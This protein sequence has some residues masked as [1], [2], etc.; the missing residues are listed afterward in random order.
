M[1]KDT[2]QV[3]TRRF[4]KEL[5]EDVN[6]FH[7][8]DNS[9]T[10]ARNAINNSKT[11]DLGKLGN[12]PSNINCINITYTGC[13]TSI[14][15]IIGTIHINADKWLIYTTNGPCH[16]IGIFTESLCTYET[17]VNDPC[18]NFSATNL[19]KGV[20]RPVV[21]CTY[22]AY[23]DDGLNP[24]RNLTFTIDPVSDNSYLNPN[25][26]IPWIQVPDP[27]NSATCNNTINS[28]NLDCNKLRLA[29][30]ID[31]PCVEVQN[32]FGSGTLLNGSYM[33]AIAYT[34]DGQKIS[35]W[36]I[37]NVQS[38]F[39]HNNSSCSLDVILTSLDTRFTEFQIV[40]ISVVNQQTV[41]KLAGVYSTHQQRLSF[42]TI[43]NTWPT[44]PIEQIPIMTPIIDKTDAT[45][46]V[47]S[48]LIRTGTTS[49]EDFN[50]QPLANQIITKW[51]SIE[52][53]SNYYI[54]G[55][56][57]TNYLRDEVYSFFIRWVYDTGDKSSA[58]HI[59]GRPKFN[60]P[61][62]DGI[63]N[64]LD[65]ITGDP[66]NEE[67]FVGNTSVFT[68]AP[69][70]ILSDGG[71]VIGEGIMGYWES[72]EQYPDDN[73]EVWNSETN[74]LNP[75]FNIPGVLPYNIQAATP[76]IGNGVSI[77]GQFD[78]CGRQIRHH[79]FPDLNTGPGSTCLY[80]DP[81]TGNIRILGVA[82][83]N[84]KAPIKNDGTPIV[85]IV[86]YEIFRGT[87]NGNK[88]ILAKGLINNMREYDLPD[89]SNKKGLYANYPYNDLGAD[90]FLS[91]TPTTGTKYPYGGGLI[92]QVGYN[93]QASINNN[94]ISFHSPDTTFVNPF[95]SAKEI[96]IHGE[97]NGNITGKFELSDKH[98]REKLIKDF[99]FVISA[100]AGLGIAAIAMN[101]Q[102]KV[103][104]V[105]PYMQ[106]FSE[107]NLPHKVDY[108]N[109]DQNA[110][111]YSSTLNA[112]GSIF[113]VAIAITG[114]LTGT[115]QNY[116]GDTS[117]DKDDLI[118]TS[119]TKAD[120]AYFNNTGSGTAIGT[121]LLKYFKTYTSTKGGLTT[122]WAKNIIGK[123]DDTL[124]YNGLN[125]AYNI[126][127]ATHNGLNTGSVNIEQADGAYQN[128]PMG[129]VGAIVA[130]IPLFFNYFT[131]GTDTALNFF[132]AV[133][134]YKDYALRYHSHCLYTN[135]NVPTTANKRRAIDHSQYIGPQ[136]ATFNST[137]KIN[138]L[139]RSNYV[140][141]QT[142]GNPLAF[143]TVGDFSRIRVTDVVALAEPSIFN[144]L[145]VKNPSK[146]SF[147]S[148]NP[149]DYSS[150]VN[151]RL[152]T[153]P[154]GTR[155]QTASSHY[156]SLKQRLRN[157]YGQIN[158][159]S[160]VPVSTCVS[161]ITGG[162]LP[163][164]STGTL[165]G[166]DTYVGRYTEK[167]TFFYFY[168]WMYGE[169]DGTQFDYTKNEMIPYP[170]YWAN[171][172]QFQTGDFT[173]SMGT[174]FTT[175]TPSAIV[176]PSSYYSLDDV[177]NTPGTWIVIPNF[178]ALSFSMEYAWFYLFNSGVKDF[179]VET[180]INLAH[181]DWG[182]LDTERFYDPGYYDDTNTLF[183]T[184]IIKATNYYKYDQ[185]L[186]YSKLFLNY[187]SWAATQRYNYNPVLAE[188]CY[189]YTKNRVIYSL[190]N[191]Y[192]SLRD[193]WSIFLINN[194][195]DFESTVTCIK[196]INKSGAMIFFESQ[197][198]VMFQ[199][200][201]TLETGLGT[202]LV[203]GDGGLFSQPLQSITNADKPYE[204]AS[205]QDRL[206]VI[207]TPMGIYWISQNQGKIFSYTNS[208]NELS[209]NDIKW[210][211]VLYLPFKLVQQ[212]PNFALTNN[213]VI[214]VGTQSIYD[215]QNGLLYF[216]KKD[217]SLRTDLPASTTVVYDDILKDNTFNI[218]VNKAYMFA[219]KLG[220]DTQ[221]VPNPIQGQPPIP[222]WQLYFEDA[223][224][225][226]SYDPK[227]DSWISY[228][229]WHPDL[230]IPG[231]NTF[232]STHNNGIWIHNSAYQSYCNYYGITYPFEVEYMVN[233]VQT[234]NTLRSIEYQLECYK[235]DNNA[236]DRFHVL[237]YNFDKAVIYN[238][239]QVSGYLRLNIDPRKDPAA[240]LTY[241][242]IGNNVINILFSKVENKYRFNQFWDITDDRG[243]YNPSAQR[244]IWNT[245]AN[246]YNRT[247]NLNNLNYAKDVFQR[248]KF[249]HYTNTVWLRKD[250]NSVLYPNGIP[251]KML[252]I[253]TNNKEL[254]SPR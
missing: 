71:V 170:R 206:S 179:Y 226:I 192:E 148:Q 216:T 156:A 187:I 82:F 45:Y 138:N 184:G 225:T 37:S 80:T 221:L 59:P 77:K 176:T 180:E 169:P 229:D 251:Y 46:S 15:K 189:V 119:P 94:I 42:D 202:K 40:I 171:F 101:G 241:P 222:I 137:Y 219:I 78:L 123:S 109:L 50:Y 88:T 110:P 191:Q 121:T 178:S 199:G 76:G 141:V 172:N 125:K 122:S 254:Y 39:N 208:L 107:E 69:N 144:K 139:Y 218:Y 79:K 190:P 24:T 6:D 68:N 73:P 26:P 224:W 99:C 85:G 86:G 35:D 20:T 21:S 175:F 150:D 32:G 162:R 142:Q 112:A 93:P 246:G 248:K 23:W 249:R 134:S 54:K 102:R 140:A 84:I 210:W 91:T 19:I 29:T 143:P 120:T 183:N 200:T 128:T 234:V 96:K 204:F 158:S 228:H 115:N 247:L 31:T 135:Y 159:I 127:T 75:G 41:A 18:L 209:M 11:G 230:V 154:K 100:L 87:R 217:Y 197:S 163:I 4:D 173:S 47:G 56:N 232:L 5:S 25:S 17:V 22:R 62:I 214:G 70:T 153:Y 10:Q 194:Y 211:L 13:G 223:S 186:S 34:V 65:S 165:F 155:P 106:G 8:P 133:I 151:N 152:A 136:I 220:D 44:V 105:S 237:D 198:P 201:D 103:N 203:I 126:E 98:P 51:Q 242:N 231:K 193:N 67:W 244:M 16:E 212:F 129:S 108:S 28:K 215:N 196:P 250:A 90:P 66:T 64:A 227:V 124:I 116:S 43:D 97:F 205:C 7:L 36:Y 236:F 72:S 185:S 132:K 161:L 174:F 95:L 117:I 61:G 167:N 2:N 149:A 252:V 131:Q 30:F 177:S 253:L 52:Y 166:G 49:K 157:Q 146:Q 81:S 89:N 182:E 239:E 238:T 147:S 60:A 164:Y 3:G 245:A 111:T 188:D 160:L 113:P 1:A 195:K 27:N 114:S 63:P 55:G 48:Y 9:W 58:Y 53:P 92:N 240:I 118:V 12:E 235:Y 74:T 213:P 57:N 168:N 145:Q 38:L 181:R 33:V 207:N 14:P 83:N 233:T 104:Y 243:E 130:N